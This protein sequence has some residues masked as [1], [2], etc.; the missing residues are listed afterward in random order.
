M[1]LFDNPQDVLEAVEQGVD[2]Q[3]VNLD[4]WHNPTGKND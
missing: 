1:L 4:L 3:E 2:I